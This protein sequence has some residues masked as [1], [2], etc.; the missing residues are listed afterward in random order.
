MADGGPGSAP[1]ID[2]S[3]LRAPGEEPL[4][5]RDKLW[6]AFDDAPEQPAML[7]KAGRAKGLPE[8]GSDLVAEF[9]A[10]RVA[11]LM[12][13][14]AARVEFATRGSTRGV[15]SYHFCPGHRL[16]HG[17]ELL[18]LMHPGYDPDKKGPNPG[19][20]LESIMHVLRDYRGY[21]QGLDAFDSFVGLLVFDALIG[22]TDRHHENWAVLEEDRALAP[23]YDH[24]AALGFNVPPGRL[25]APAVAAR[26][27]RARHFPGKLTLVEL[28]ESG[29]GMIAPSA[30][31]HWLAR[32]GSVSQDA[33]ERIVASVPEGWLSDPRRI[34]VI[35]LLAENQRRLRS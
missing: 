33:V 19:Y 13:I 15:V 12:D 28:A 7:W 14:P 31:E 23:S 34:F 30:A 11:A 18:P 1:V 29:L 16:V 10:A 22:N 35:E 17:N 5:A 6:L 32:V 25:G 4:G 26:R 2:V 21:G 3:H 27:G 24:G 20:N 8:P 9:I